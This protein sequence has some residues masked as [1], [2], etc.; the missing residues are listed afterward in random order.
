MRGSAVMPASAENVL[1]ATEDYEART[2]W[3]ELFISGKIVHSIDENHAV[4]HFQFKVR[5]NFT[6]PIPK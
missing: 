5:E 2:H 3:D 1:K 4:I 6:S